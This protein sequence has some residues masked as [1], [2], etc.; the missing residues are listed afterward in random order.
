MQKRPKF[1]PK[2]DQGKYAETFGGNLLGAGRR[3]IPGWR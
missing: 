1:D 2:V 3:A